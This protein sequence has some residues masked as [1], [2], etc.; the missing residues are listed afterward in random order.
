[1]R[2][3]NEQHINEILSAFTKR[4]KIAT[5]LRTSKIK[6]GWE[7]MMGSMIAGYTESLKLYKGKLT[8][9]LSSPALRHE[10]MHNNEL[11]ISKINNYL[12]EKIV[13]EIKLR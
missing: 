9:E 12:G 1:M 5:K 11:L 4:P 10:L 6:E 13:E 3:Q 8:I 7:E 2:N